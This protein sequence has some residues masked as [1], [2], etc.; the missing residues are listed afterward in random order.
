MPSHDGL[1]LDEE[2]GIPPAAPRPPQR[3]PEHALF[4]LEPRKRLRLHQGVDLLTQR[5]VLE[6]EV[7]A[8]AAQRPKA[9][10]QEGQ[11]KVQG[12]HEGPC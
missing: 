6:Q 1:G 12:L 7:G 11:H 10:E 5:H 3:H 9:V 2:E 4:R 8:R